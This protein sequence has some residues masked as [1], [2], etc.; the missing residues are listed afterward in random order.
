MTAN[1]QRVSV[2]GDETILETVM[3]A[4]S[5]VNIVNATEWLQWRVL[6]LTRCTGASSGLLAVWADESCPSVK[7][8]SDT[9][10]S[11]PRWLTA[12]DPGTQP[13]RSRHRA[14]QEPSAAPGVDRDG[15]MR[16]WRGPRSAQPSLPA[17]HPDLSPS[18]TSTAT[19][20]FPR[21]SEVMPVTRA[22][23]PE[24]FLGTG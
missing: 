8:G 7:Q 1:R 4:P 20:K 18:R 9:L 22:P 14:D 21:T 13:H 3:T 5:M 11:F 10:Q 17:P 19:C 2:W 15:D 16:A 24:P 23:C 12:H 6:R